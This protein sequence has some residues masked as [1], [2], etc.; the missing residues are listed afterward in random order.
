MLNTA[1]NFE[2][3][4][5]RFDFFFMRILKLIL[6]LMF[7]KMEVSQVRLNVMIG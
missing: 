6:L 2:K 7:V 3:A 4:F 5:D 1:Q